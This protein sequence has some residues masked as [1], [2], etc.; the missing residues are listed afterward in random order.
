MLRQLM[1]HTKR[2]LSLS[3][4]FSMLLPMVVLPASAN[5]AEMEWGGTDATGAILTG[6]NCPLTVEHELLTFQIEQFPESYYRA[7]DDFLTYTG[8]VTAE[9]TFHNPAD[10]TVNATLVFPFGAVPDYTPIRDRNTNVI[11]SSA[12]IEKYE[13]TVDG[14]TI[15]R[16]LRHTLTSRGEQFEPDRDMAE[17]RMG[18][19]P[20]PAF[21]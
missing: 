13:I 8:S 5:S 9:Y 20:L 12:D 2:L 1:Y 4:L 21:L 15:D 19:I 17:S 3:L 16:T 11:L 18:I 6:E 7:A 10:Y 14:Q